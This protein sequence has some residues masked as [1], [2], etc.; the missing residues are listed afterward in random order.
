MLVAALRARRSSSERKLRADTSQQHAIASI[1]FHL[2]HHINHRLID[3]DSENCLS[4]YTT[5]SLVGAPTLVSAKPTSAWI[6]FLDHDAFQSALQA[7]TIVT[8][9]LG[10]ISLCA[11]FFPTSYTNPLGKQQHSMSCC[12]DSSWNVGS[13]P[14]FWKG[15]VYVLPQL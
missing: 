15:R 11:L 7:D 3:A 12:L 8:R 6:F 5:V 10:D 14:K 4:E 9:T 1:H 13:R 2:D